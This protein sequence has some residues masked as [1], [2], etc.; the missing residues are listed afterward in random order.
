[1][2]HPLTFRHSRTTFATLVHRGE[3]FVGSLVPEGPVCRFVTPDGQ[4]SGLDT[5]DAWR[6]ALVAAGAGL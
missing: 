5:E 3:F 4:R 6:R 1:M 2:T